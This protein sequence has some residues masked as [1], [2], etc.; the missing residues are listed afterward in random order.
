[1]FCTNCGHKLYDDAVF[2]SYCGIKLH[3]EE[4]ES[5]VSVSAPMI[6]PESQVG[7]ADNENR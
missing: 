2:C 4:N 5:A 3:K 1:M 7:P 6:K